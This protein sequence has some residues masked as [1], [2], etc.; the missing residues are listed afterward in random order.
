MAPPP[1]QATFTAVAVPL[2][3]DPLIYTVPPGTT[4]GVIEVTAPTAITGVK[5]ATTASR[6]RTQA[7]ENTLNSFL[8]LTD[9]STR[10]NS[11]YYDLRE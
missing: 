7:A 11:L 3:P 4:V 2:K 10:Y 1:V 9:T 8:N 5:D 6:P